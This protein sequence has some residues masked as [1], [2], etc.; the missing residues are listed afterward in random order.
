MTAI[1]LRLP[2][3]YR[4]AWHFCGLDGFVQFESGRDW[5]TRDKEEAEWRLTQLRNKF[6][7]RI[8]FWLEGETE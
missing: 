7:G 2:P 8:I 6:A 5:G 3:R 4:I 1:I